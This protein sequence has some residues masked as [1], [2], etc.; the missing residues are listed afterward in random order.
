MLLQLALQAS[1]TVFMKDIVLYT[2]INQRNCSGQHFFCSCFVSFSADFLD[3][4]PGSGQLVSI[5]QTTSG[6]LTDPLLGTRII[7]HIFFA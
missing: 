3:S 2:L 5:T 6:V 7:S 1:S 4:S